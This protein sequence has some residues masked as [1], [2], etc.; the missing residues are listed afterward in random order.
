MAARGLLVAQPLLE[1]SPREVGLG[2][3]RGRRDGGGGGPERR[4]NYE[5]DIAA[6]ERERAQA[7]VRMITRGEMEAKVEML[8][9][10]QIMILIEMELQIRMNT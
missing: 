3:A 2:G 6:M 4:P 7:A 9:L 10:R 1:L 5:D 8:F